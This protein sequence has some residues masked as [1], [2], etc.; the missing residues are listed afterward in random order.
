MEWLGHKVDFLL[1]FKE[2][3]TLIPIIAAPVCKVVNEDSFPLYP[4]QHLLSIVL[5]I[6]AT[7]TGVR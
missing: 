2:F 4:L 1:A 7:L 6:F 3:S 5:L